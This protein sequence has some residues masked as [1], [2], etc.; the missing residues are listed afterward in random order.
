[1]KKTMII[2]SILFG[3]F[4]ICSNLQASTDFWEIFDDIML[5]NNITPEEVK[6]FRTVQ[7]SPR[8]GKKYYKTWTVIGVTSDTITLQR[9]KSNDELDEVK[10]ER[11]RR[12]YLKVGDR[13]RYDNVRNRLRSTVKKKREP[14]E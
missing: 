4:L 14:A 10:I 9:K 13:V 3:S 11:S 6:Q 8:K 5:E 12:P 7:A 2:I 1:M